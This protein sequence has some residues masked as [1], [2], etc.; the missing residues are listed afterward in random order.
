ML[1]LHEVDA[2]IGLLGAEGTDAG[3]EDEKDA[4]ME[5]RKALFDLYLLPLTARH[6]ACV[7]L[8][9]SRTSGRAL[10][11]LR[12]KTFAIMVQRRLSELGPLFLRPLCRLPGLDPPWNPTVQKMTLLVLGELEGFYDD[13]FCHLRQELH[14]VVEICGHIDCGQSCES[15]GVDLLPRCA[16]GNQPLKCFGTFAVNDRKR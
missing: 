3:E 7:A 1:L 15:S 5:E 9:N 6:C 10:Q 8:E 2:L 14:R 16:G 12:N 11:F 4:E 13:G